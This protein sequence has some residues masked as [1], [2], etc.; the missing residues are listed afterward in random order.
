MRGEPRRQHALDHQH[1][2]GDD[3][4]LATGQI[5]SAVDAVEVAEVVGPRVIRVGDVDDVRDPTIAV[6][7]H[8]LLHAANVRAPVVGYRKRDV[9]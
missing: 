2:L 5:G 9:P 7:L 8:L 1:A 6:W 3:Q 4:T